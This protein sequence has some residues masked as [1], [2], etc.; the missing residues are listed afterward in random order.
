MNFARCDP[1]SHRLLAIRAKMNRSAY[2][3]HPGTLHSMTAS[4]TGDWPEL[5]RDL[6]VMLSDLRAARPTS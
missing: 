2:A 4:M 5:T 6:N 3:I 1:N